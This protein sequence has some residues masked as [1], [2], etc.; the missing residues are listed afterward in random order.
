MSGPDHCEQYMEESASADRVMPFVQ[1]RR[2]SRARKH[3]ASKA[4]QRPPTSRR[5]P[6]PLLL[7]PPTRGTSYRDSADARG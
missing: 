4:H 2:A 5:P 7:L 6:L 1:A 3:N